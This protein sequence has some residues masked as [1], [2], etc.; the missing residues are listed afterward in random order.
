VRQKCLVLALRR[1]PVRLPRGARPRRRREAES[2]WREFLRSLRA[3]GLQGVRWCVLDAQE[4]L[5]RQSRRSF[6]CPWQALHRALYSNNSTPPTTHVITP[7]LHDPAVEEPLEVV[8][9]EV[10]SASRPL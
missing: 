2:F 1:P 8:T 3:R 4:G 5:K 9:G 7:L 10:R 6:D